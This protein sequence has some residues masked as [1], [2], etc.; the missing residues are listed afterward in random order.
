METSKNQVEKKES[1]KRPYSA[2]K[3]VEYGDVAKLTAGSS[4]GSPDLTGKRTCL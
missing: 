1:Q 2:P 4:G 3:L